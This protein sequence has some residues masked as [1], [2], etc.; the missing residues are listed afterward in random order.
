MHFHSSGCF[1]FNSPGILLQF[2]TMCY[3]CSGRVGGNVVLLR[4]GGNLTL[5]YPTLPYPNY[6]TYIYNISCPTLP[7]TPSGSTFFY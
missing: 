3:V 4:Q 7:P 2:V 1:V 6:T 5:P